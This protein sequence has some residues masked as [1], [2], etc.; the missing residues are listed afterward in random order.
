MK[1]IKYIF[2][3]MFLLSVVSACD[4]TEVEN[5]DFKKD[6]E[7]YSNIIEIRNVL[8]NVYS[9][10]PAGYADLGA[11]WLAAASD[12]AEEVNNFETIQNF[13]N[14][15]ITA[16]ANPDDVWAKNY[17][18][19]Y[20][21]KVFLQGTD[22]VTWK[23]YQL[24]N[25]TVYAD[26]V[27]LTKQYRAEARFLIAFFYFDLIKRYGGVPIVDEIINVNDPNWI[28]RFPR[29]PFSDCIDFVVAIC[30]A[31]AADLPTAASELGRATKGAALALKARALL[32]AASDL[33]NQ[34]GN[35]NPLYGY[36]DANRT[37]RLIKAAEASKAIM[38]FTPAYAFQATYEALSLLGTTKSNEVIFERRYSA[39]NTFEKQQTP[40][41]FPQG[42]TG[43]CPSGNLVDAYEMSNGTN[44]DWNN[45]SQAA[46]PYTGRDP[47]LA[48]TIV[49]NNAVFNKALY[50]VEA[51]N[52]GINGRPRDRAT[53]TGYYL[54]KWINE[55][56][57]LQLNETSTKQWIFM[58]LSEFYL[59][60]AEA[61]NELYGPSGTG[62]GTL[63]ITAL[64]ALNSVRTRA[65]VAMPAILA[66]GQTQATLRDRIRKERRIE[67][68]FE[69]HRFWD[70][71][72][73]MIA[74]HTLGAALTGVSI[75]KNVNNSFTY[76]PM[77]VENRIWDDKLY[78]YPI[79]QTEIDKSNR[80]LIQNKGW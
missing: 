40:V 71:R 47:R 59:S 31:A 41:G 63:N 66:A 75:I 22:T 50:T 19:V 28:S 42:Q 25:P 79:P 14:G 65:A 20:N 54:R 32:Y 49:T 3:T 21:A 52:G 23:S 5:L 58:R 34:A 4:V 77:T 2:A 64:S 78:F 1:N 70:V 53:K 76:A 29:K 30:D 36:T 13:N 57:D 39:S 15:G 55:N 6:N 62:P 72:R 38:N 11:S 69:G 74:P 10:L 48:K 24:S 43:T 80:V 51:F 45:P 44:F 33:Y 17:E 18:G 8:N 67:L 16:F 68:A 61:M 46:S 56:L 60:Y 73:W 12:E 27:N 26:R 7:I 37:S 9:T 35:T